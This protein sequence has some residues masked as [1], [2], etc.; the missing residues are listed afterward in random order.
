MADEVSPARRFPGARTL[1]GVGPSSG[2]GVSRSEIR[3]AIDVAMGV[4]AATWRL[5]RGR[6]VNVF[7]NEIVDAAV[8][9]AGRLVAA[10]LTRVPGGYPE[11][12]RVHDLGGALVRPGYVDGHVH[13][14][15]SLVTPAQYARCLLPRG[16]TG[17][18]CDP[19]ELAN[20]AGEEGVRWLLDA[21]AELPFDVWVTVPSCVPSSPFETVGGEF[22]P[23]AMERLMDDPRVVGVAELMSFSDVIAGDE[24][25][26]AKAFLGEERGLCVEGHA[27][28][29]VGPGLQ[30]Y[31]AS[32]V[33]SDHES[34]T[35]EE[36]REKLRSGAFLMI[37]EGS[38]TRDLDAL[39]PLVDSRN[40][41]RVGFV[42]DDRLPH[43]LLHEGG[44]DLLVQRAVLAGMD[45]AYAARCASYNVANHFGLPRRG[46][47][48]AGYVADLAVCRDLTAMPELV[49]KEGVLV[50]RDGELLEGAS[51][52]AGWGVGDGVPT[53]LLRSVRL[54]RLTEESFRLT[55]PAG[56][57]RVIR[58]TP[59]QILTRGETA[60]P[61]VEEGLVVAD[62]TRDL[63]KLACVERHGKGGAV[64][65][66]LVSGFGMGRGALA[67]S[68]GH[69]HH[70]LMCVGAND[71]DMLV[72]CSRLRDLGGGLVAIDE[73]VVLAELPLP[74]GGLLT[75]LTLEDT[76]DLL[77]DLDAAARALGCELPSPYMALSFLGLAVIPELRLTDL[78]LVDVTAR[79][80]VPFGA[81]E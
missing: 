15:S 7:T 45:P 32:G 75:D 52:D 17:V 20:V 80:L 30:A 79:K 60:L 40:G 18:V 1:K 65:V 69:D 35:L 12:E 38:V 56:K 9:L 57:A 31:L 76:R 74:F 24:E 59:N 27:P 10:V 22:G 63:L 70:N 49:F 53:A 44:V 47:V 62:P 37:R 41:D 6:V 29:L 2:S 61:T 36:G 28:S 72:A 39:M 5:E 66:G 26:L 78:G 48:A 8:L 50:A 42:T 34:T 54:P 67:S 51:G 58:A 68:V 13:L 71:A 16:V 4:S 11:A 23:A 19:H 3:R 77:D 73:G 43:D 21:S 25:V 64:G 55:A 46:A 33:A 14:E 81:G